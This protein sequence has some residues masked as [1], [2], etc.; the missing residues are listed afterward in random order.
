[1]RFYRYLLIILLSSLLVSLEKHDIRIAL[2]PI[3][4][5][6]HIFLSS[7]Q[8]FLGVPLRPQEDDEALW[9]KDAH[10]QAITRR[11]DGKDLHSNRVLPWRAD[12]GWDKGHPDNTEDQH[13]EGDEL[14]LIE[15][16][17]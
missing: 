10:Q 12:V 9:S 3:V 11:Q 6:M 1:M 4:M 16:I 13:A 17:R 2:L 14:G 7:H 5:Y 8:L 15:V